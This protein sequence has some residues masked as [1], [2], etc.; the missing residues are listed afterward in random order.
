MC[1]NEPYLHS[2]VGV[3]NNNV[4]LQGIAPSITHKPNSAEWLPPC[5]RKHVDAQLPTAA[6]CQLPLLGAIQ[7]SYMR[8]VNF[9]SFA[10]MKCRQA[11]GC[12]SV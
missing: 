10:N 6:A 8:R 1:L 12:H 2:G 11:A 9:M 4:S 3:I 5:L 7:H